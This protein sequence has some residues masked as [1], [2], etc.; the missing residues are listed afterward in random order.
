MVATI[1]GDIQL[2][3][4]HESIVT[5]NNPPGHSLCCN[6]RSITAAV[7]CSC[8]SGDIGDMTIW[9]NILEYMVYIYILD[10]VYII[11]IY[12]IYYNIIYICI[13][14]KI[15][16]NHPIYFAIFF[17]MISPFF[18]DHRGQETPSWLRHHGSTGLR[19]PGTWGVPWKNGEKM[20]EKWWFHGT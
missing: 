1:L 14:M 12:I 19:R 4:K 15:I 18:L 7:V 11:Y 9:S 13:S 17:S 5:P 3:N 20:L 10:M 8:W 16:E 6:L 2:T